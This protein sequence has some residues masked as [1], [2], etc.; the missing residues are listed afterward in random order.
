MQ[1]TY[2]V[3]HRS[4]KRTK[5]QKLKDGQW[6][7]KTSSRTNESCHTKVRDPLNSRHLI[8]FRVLIMTT[9][10]CCGWK[11]TRTIKRMT[12]FGNG[13]SA[14]RK[15][16]RGRIYFYPPNNPF[17]SCLGVQGKGDFWKCVPV[18]IFWEILVSK[19]VCFDHMST[20]Y[21]FQIKCYCQL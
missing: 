11:T 1:R 13:F 8:G 10:H 16:T 17:G 3:A 4:E 5:S 12:F 20:E 18:S 7:M 21:P 2:K 19:W 15:K 9:W 6:T 14:G